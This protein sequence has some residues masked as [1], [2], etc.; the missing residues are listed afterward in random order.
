MR[1]TELK[2]ICF[3]LFIP[4]ILPVFAADNSVIFTSVNK[5][6]V[7]MSTSDTG[8]ESD[9]AIDGQGFLHISYYDATNGDLKYARQLRGDLGF[10]S[11][12]MNAA[13]YGDWVVF[14]VDSVGTVGRY[15]SIKVDSLGRPCISYYDVKNKALKFARFDGQKWVIQ[16]V[17]SGN[18]G[19]Y[20]ALALDRGD[21]PYISYYDAKRG[22]LKCANHDG[23]KWNVEE[24]DKEN[25]GDLGLYTSIAIGVD[26]LARISYYDNKNGKLKF[27]KSTGL[28]WITEDVDSGEN[29]KSGIYSS[30]VLG[31][32]DT[33]HIAYYDTTNNN[34][35][36]AV[37]KGFS[38]DKQIVDNNK[39]VGQ[40]ASLKL[41]NGGNPWIAYYDSDSKKLKL[42]QFNGSTWYTGFP[43][44]NAN[45]YGM[46]CSLA[47]DKANNWH[48]TCRDLGTRKLVYLNSKS[49]SSVKKKNWWLFGAD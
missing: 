26:G 47:I 45:E 40:F 21:K 41:D 49:H 33:P 29:Y 9:I 5:Y 16:Y 13:K 4:V 37:K 43:I 28:D 39:N 15:S 8:Y 6:T 11:K 32:N 17:D 23:F 10:D 3:I 19:I 20:T 44:S 22:T 1:I 24:V 2:K 30:M 25:H 36:Y 12:K 35:R 18:V 48:I 7:D 34:L 42:A 38:W 31:N 14:T 46:D 27:A